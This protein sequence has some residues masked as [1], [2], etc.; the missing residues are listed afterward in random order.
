MIVT[1]TL[2]S[3]IKD[4]F[5]LKWDGVHGVSHWSRVR[6]NGLRLAKLNGANTKV[7]EYFAFL[8][9]ACRI[10]DG[11]DENHG[12]RAATFAKSLLGK[13]VHLSL[14]EFLDLEVACIGHSDGLTSDLSVTV[15]SCWDADRLDLGRVGVH[16]DPRY[17][18]T[19]EAQSN[20]MLQWAYG[21]S[22]I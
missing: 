13:Y 18:C 1:Q 17:L 19:E 4:Q 3:V 21:N 9:D 6:N 15:M 7:I 20:E 22:Q 12:M 14:K 10:T 5:Q 11:S 8:H 16:P 2:I